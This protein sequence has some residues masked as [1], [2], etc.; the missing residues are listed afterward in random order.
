MTD[1]FTQGVLG[2]PAA[3]VAVKAAPGTVAVLIVDDDD[4]YVSFVRQAFDSSTD[5]HIE[6]IHVRRLSEI[7]PVLLSTSIAVI[8]LDVELPDGNG[9][10]WLR[11]NRS[12]V[13]AAVIVITGHAEYNHEA[14]LD[15]AQ[16]FVVKWE[17]EPSHLVRAV[18]YA[19]DRERVRQQLLR[20]REYFQ[21]LI[22]QARDLITVVDEHAV[23]VYQSPACTRILGLP[24][25]A[26][27]GRP[28]LDFVA[29][30]DVPRVRAMLVSLFASGD[31]L[32]ADEFKVQ[33]VDGAFR[34][35]ETVA[36]R[37]PSVGGSRR[38][39]LNSR[40]VSERRRAEEAL[41]QRDEQLRQAQ[42]MEAV[43]RMAG[44]IAH[45]FSNVLTVIT[46]AS[47]RLRDTLDPQ[48]HALHDVDTI[49]KNCQRAASLTRQLLAFSRQQTLAPRPIDL[50]ALVRNTGQ[51]LT[52]LIGEDVRLKMDVDPELTAIEA[53]PVQMEQVLMNLAINARDAMPNGGSLRI[54][55]HNV[56]VNDEFAST[57]APMAT[58]NYVLLQVSD[59]GCGM[60]PETKAHAFEPFFTTKD[61][62]HGTGLGLSTV[63]GI[64]KQ[65]GGFIWIDSE[66]GAGTTFHVYMT[67]TSRPVVEERPRQSSH[68]PVRSA[69]I[70]L[71]EDEEDV[72]ELLSDVLAS[73][74]YT[75]L[76]ANSPDDAYRAATQYEK[77]IDLLLTDVVMPG[78]TGPELARRLAGHRPGLKVLYMSGY[79]EHGAAHGSVLD[80][81]APFL[82]KPFTRDLLLDKVRDL[83]G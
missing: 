66:P 33:H 61:P 34:T 35:V 63:Y 64:V 21:S 23:I 14:E 16:D 40:D 18:R 74:G 19:A 60:T 26:F 51:L 10:E 22:D 56:T 12:K 27:I 70:L 31:T 82:Q 78:G 4:R 37:I 72:R 11:D 68:G 55:V 50:G 8:L 65:S 71:T 5:P 39:V 38:I 3:E 73:H 15:G 81:G 47:E 20:S 13:Q 42:K 36:S 69:T 80:P 53:D 25:E 79:P 45:D 52:Q 77:R 43:G 75:V 83:L 6:L 1:V 2:R 76:Q 59:T 24:P 28:F 58:G 30:V 57:H 29:E 46:A 17:V 54:A 9:L 32:P 62:V 48:S 41:R 67:P 49:L 44:G 7:R